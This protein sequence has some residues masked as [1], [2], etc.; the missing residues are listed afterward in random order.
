MLSLGDSVSH[1]SV[2]RA[3]DIIIKNVLNFSLHSHSHSI[4]GLVKTS[5]KYVSTSPNMQVNVCYTTKTKPEVVSNSH[6]TTKLYHLS[7]L[8][9][10]HNQV[11]SLPRV[12]SMPPN[13]GHRRMNEVFPVYTYFIIDSVTY[14]LHP[15]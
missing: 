8:E 5:S 11:H 2:C 4:F 9:G 10:T 15:E 13:C 6:Y 14:V 12:E 3:N 1:H 7:S